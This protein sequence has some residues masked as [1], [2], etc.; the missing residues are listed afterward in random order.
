MLTL[1][2]IVILSKAIFLDRANRESAVKQARQA[3][4]DIHKNQAS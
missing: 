2:S 4:T 1:P 3:A